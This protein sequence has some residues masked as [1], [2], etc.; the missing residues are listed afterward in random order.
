GVEK[1]SYLATCAEVQTDLKTGSLKIIRAVSAFECGA[2]VNAD[3]LKNQIEGAL[4]MG[5]GG[6]LFEAIEFEN[7]KITNPRLSEY[8]VPRVSAAHEIEVVL[9]N[10]KDIPSI[11][12]GE[13]PIIGIAPAI[14]N[15]IL[16]AT[17]IRLAN[18]PMAPD[19]LKA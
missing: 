18:L 15:A 17:G 6:A 11:G 1:G 4:V 2:I 8:R 13:T 9:V 5:I 14:R 19:G 12:A 3:H 7:G 10:R 16:H